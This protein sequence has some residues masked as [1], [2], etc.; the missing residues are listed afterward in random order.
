[1]G[2]PEGQDDAGRR[3]R[4][5]A[6]SGRG[7]LQPGLPPPPP[8]DGGPGPV[9]PGKR[10]LAA[11]GKDLVKRA[12]LRK[13]RYM[14]VFNGLVDPF[15]SGRLG[16]L[17]RLDSPHPVLYV[18]FPQGRLKLQGT[19]VFPKSTNYALLNVDKRDHIGVEDIFESMV[20]FSDA[21]W[22]GTEAENP[23]EDPLPVPAGVLAGKAGR[24]EAIAYECGAATEY[25]AQPGA[26]AAASDADSDPE[27]V[28]LEVGVGARGRK[29][30][31][32]GASNPPKKKAKKADL[33]PGPVDLASSSEDEAGETSGDGDSNFEASSG[34]EAELVPRRQS[35]GRSAR[36]GAIREVSSDSD[37]DGG[38]P[39]AAV[40]E[41]G[42][43]GGEEEEGA[44]VAE[45]K[46]EEEG[47]AMTEPPP[48]GAGRRL[49]E[50]IQTMNDQDVAN[51]LA[52]TGSMS[53]EM[54][55]VVDGAVRQRE[56]AKE[57]SKPVEVVT[58][59]F[60]SD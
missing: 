23:G 51:V 43:D 12:G 15:K 54:Q 1:M 47:A 10:L 42:G 36:R 40:G 46:E 59:D 8:A 19:L 41:E 49:W 56:A 9:G 7:P 11:A 30:P 20:V 33:K 22:V 50:R 48:D 55:R 57:R 35:M 34:E 45:G 16:S 38:A 58:L 5:R 21:Y 37:G 13:N 2:R 53:P 3:L 18:E 27:P 60:D 6:T 28:R 31:P 39:E 24:G 29:A 17:A 26:G 32:P 4:A 25:V 14:L 44:A 52:R